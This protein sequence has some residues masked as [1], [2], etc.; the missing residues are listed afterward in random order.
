MATYQDII[1]G[2]MSK[3]SKNQPKVIATQT[4]ELRGQI[5]RILQGAYSFAAILN[6]TRFSAKEAI[7]GVGGAWARPGA[8]EA[9]VRITQT[10]AGTEVAVVPYDDEQAEPA[11]QAVY[12]FAGAFNSASGPALSPGPTDSLTFWYARRPTLHTGTLVLTDVLDPVDGTVHPGT[13]RWI[14]AYNE[15]IIL[16]LAI[17]LSRK[18]GRVDE[19]QAM[20]PDRDAWATRFASW[21]QR[22]TAIERSRFGGRHIHNVETLIPMIGGG[23]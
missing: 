1:D 22:G 8:A 3:S 21:L 23:S 7:V 6:P 2:A 17:Y 9:I 13:S 14:D 15:L 10:I 4:V 20:T 11:T 16:E 18:D 12:E 5:D 19:V